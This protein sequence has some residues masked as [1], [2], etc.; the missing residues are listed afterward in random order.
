[1]GAAV[2]FAVSNPS[3]RN[4]IELGVV[5]LFVAILLLP[6]AMGRLLRS[7]EYDIG[8]RWQTTLVVIATLGVERACGYLLLL[9]AQGQIG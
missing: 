6:L 9:M 5:P 3:L 4:T 1:M 7:V 8:L 2:V